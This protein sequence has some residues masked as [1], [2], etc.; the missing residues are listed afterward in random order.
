MAHKKVSKPKADAEKAVAKANTDKRKSVNLLHNLAQK[1]AN[2][3]LSAQ[4]DLLNPTKHKT[5]RGNGSPL[6]NSRVKR[7]L[8]RVG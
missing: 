3:I 2:S 5:H 7:A 4:S 6:R 1:D 8:S